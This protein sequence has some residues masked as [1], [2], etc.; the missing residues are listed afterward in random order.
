MIKQPQDKI[1]PTKDSKEETPNE[2]TIIDTSIFSDH[3]RQKFKGIISKIA[4]TGVTLLFQINTNYYNEQASGQ[5]VLF[6]DPNLVF[7]YR[8]IAPKSNE[9][10]PDELVL[11]FLD[12]DVLLL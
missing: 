12:S 6:I 4:E 2:D 3:I 10:N 1:I 11:A 9:Q 7:Q 5:K 8:L